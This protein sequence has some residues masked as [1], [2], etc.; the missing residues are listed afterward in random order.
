MKNVLLS[1]T[2][3]AFAFMAGPA[4][5]AAGSTGAAEEAQSRP[6]PVPKMTKEEKAAAR[7]ER[8]ASATAMKKP[9]PGASLE[10]GN[11]SKGTAKSATKEEKAAARAERKTSAAAAQKAGEIPSGDKPMP[12]PK[13]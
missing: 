3:A 4:A 11:K 2:L 8:K 12:E 9:S 10:A 6:A 5:M 13:K 1:V 7:A